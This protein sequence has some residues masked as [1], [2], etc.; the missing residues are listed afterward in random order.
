MWQPFCI[1]FAYSHQYNLIFI[2]KGRAESY[3]VFQSLA[4]PIGGYSEHNLLAIGN[5]VLLSDCWIVC[6]T[7]GLDIYSVIDLSDVGI[8]EERLS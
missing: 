8:L 6:S 7:E 3:K 1:V 5:I 2:I 4:I